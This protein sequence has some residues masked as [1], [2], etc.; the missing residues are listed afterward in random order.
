MPTNTLSLFYYNTT[1]NKWYEART[2]AGHSALRECTITKII[3]NPS[4]AKIILSNPSKNSQTTDTTKSKG[5]LSDVFPDYTHLIIRDNATG[6]ILFRGRSYE[7]Q[8]RYDLSKGALIEIDAYD[9]LR[10]LQETI[11]LDTKNIIQN[12]DITT[13]DGI[14]T[15]EYS[16]Q[17][18]LDGAM[19]DVT[20]STNGFGYRIQFAV[21]AQS[22]TVE[23]VIKPGEVFKIDNEYFR[24]EYVAEN[25]ILGVRGIVMDGSATVEAHADG[26]SLLKVSAVR[27]STNR[28]R[29]NLIK[30]LISR[31]N[32]LISTSL[33]ADNPTNIEPSEFQ[34]T[35]EELTNY[36]LAGDGS[37]RL[38]SIA[39][40]RS[41]L[42]QEIHN[43]ALSDP[44]SNT[45]NATHFGYDYYLG[46][47]VISHLS[48]GATTSFNPT[49]KGYAPEFHYF[50]RGSRPGIGADS[51]FP[52][53]A[54]DTLKVWESSKSV[55]VATITAV[56]N[57]SPSRGTSQS[58]TVSNVDILESLASTFKKDNNDY[59]YNVDV[60][61]NYTVTDGLVIAI[62]KEE[63][64]VTNVT[65]GNNTL[66]VLRGVNNS[67]ISTHADDSPIYIN[68]RLNAQ[69]DKFG[70]TFWYP[71]SEGTGHF[72]SLNAKYKNTSDIPLQASSSF[73]FEDSGYY[74]GVSATFV[75]K[76]NPA[77]ADSEDT[78]GAEDET[79]VVTFEKMPC[80]LGVTDNKVHFV[81]DSDS[82]LGNAR[83]TDD[84]PT[85]PYV[86]VIAQSTRKKNVLASNQRTQFLY[87][88]VKDGSSS[89]I[90]TNPCAVLVSATSNTSPSDTDDYNDTIIL[91]HVHDKDNTLITSADAA[92]QTTMRAQ[93]RTYYDTETEQQIIFEPFPTDEDLPTGE[94]ALYLYGDNITGQARPHLR[95]KPSAARARNRLGL[96]KVGVLEVPSTHRNSK[97]ILQSLSRYLDVKTS[98]R[99][100][101]SH[102]NILSHPHLTLYIENDNISR[103]TYVSSSSGTSGN[104]IIFQSDGSGNKAFINGTTSGASNNLLLHGA[105]LGSVIA[106]LN[107]FNQIVR[108]AYI[109]DINYDVTNDK[110]YL[111]Y[112]VGATDTSDGGQFLIS[113][114]LAADSGTGTS[115]T[116]LTNTG[117]YYN[118][119]EIIKIG[120]EYMLI[121]GV[122]ASG[123]TVQRGYSLSTPATVDSGSIAN[124][125]SGANIRSY[126]KVAIFIPTE[127]GHTV[128]VKHNRVGV[129]Y[130]SIVQTIEHVY[131]GGHVT[132]YIDSIGLINSVGMPSQTSTVPSVPTEDMPNLPDMWGSDS[133]DEKIN[134][135][136]KSI[137]TGKLIPHNQSTMA[138]I[139]T[140]KTQLAAA[141]NDSATTIAVD[142]ASVFKAG[143]AVMVDTEEM[144]ITSI[145]GNTLTIYRG[146]SSE[147]GY[148]GTTRASHSDDEYISRSHVFVTSKAGVVKIK[149]SDPDI[150]GG[151]DIAG[152]NSN[153]NY[154]LHEKHMVF[155]RRK[156][157]VTGETKFGGSFQLQAYPLNRNDKT[158][159]EEDRFPL[160]NAGSTAGN[161]G[162][163]RRKGDIE[164]GI[165]QYDADNDICK[166]EESPKLAE[167][168]FD[169][170]QAVNSKLLKNNLSAIKVKQ[171]GQYWSTNLKIEGTAW[172]QIKFGLKGSIGSDATV[173]FGDD[174]TQ[175]I[176]ASDESAKY[177][178]LS[179]PSGM[180][181][182]SPSFTLPADTSVYLYKTVSTAASTTDTGKTLYFT[183]N[184]TDVYQDDRIL[185]AVIT[186]AASSDA[187]GDEATPAIF[188]FGGAD[189]TFTSAV[190]KAGVFTTGITAAMDGVEINA[191]GQ[192]K[193]PTNKSY[194]SAVNGY[195]LEVNKQ[196]DGS[197]K[198]RFEIGKNDGQYLRWTGDN[199][200]IRGSIKTASNGAELTESLGLYFADSSSSVG[201]VQ[202]LNTQNTSGG[203]ASYTS[204]FKNAGDNLAIRND[205]AAVKT[206][207][208]YGLNL[209]LYNNLTVQGNI[210]GNVTFSNDVLFN[211]DVLFKGLMKT[212]SSPSS[213]AGLESIDLGGGNYRYELVRDTSSRKYKTNIE[214][215]TL[216]SA[217]IYNLNPVSFT[218]K[219]SNKPA[220]GLIAEEVY[221][222]LPELVSLLDG[223]PDTVN[224][225]RLPVLLLAEIK[226]LKTRI[227]TLENS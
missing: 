143:N 51:V 177:T 71:S 35:P 32:S 161:V 184:Y 15:S 99:P 26:A 181:Y 80:A 88:G 56:I 117:T 156:K 72:K 116:I 30:Y 196:G 24:A 137:T 130:N 227:E 20:A 50:K 64:L 167:S 139:S 164:F 169:I 108:Y 83:W 74:T 199:L 41:N 121:T 221:E 151:L 136:F 146:E 58:I 214:S 87:A 101:T 118:E 207:D 208:I 122:G 106:E 97:L 134:E 111:L 112:G 149:I 16:P 77:A 180:S 113:S 179:Y 217:K 66:T 209:D 166:W 141:L 172:N 37:K 4:M 25:T 138:L 133:S 54:A 21:T 23:G 5:N 178:G 218:T 86:D 43:L 62:D 102:L 31:S 110:T 34:F 46:N 73:D 59:R 2:H 197:Y 98:E 182:S 202:W 119:G 189:A 192:I 195:I 158:E 18:D 123:L 226:K 225:N 100:V 155:F 205:G 194:N 128:R 36:E 81:D 13:V 70:L 220:F 191:L 216:D 163:Y 49:Q 14:T 39:A 153:D 95:I 63:F 42:L 67:P 211:D 120:N 29:S 82:F 168:V 60:N 79:H 10:E 85:N 68:T 109:S 9:A 190:I 200:E 8:D 124:H 154:S 11:L 132:T 126:R 6:I 28:Q 187:A 75:I 183:T 170:S 160:W 222:V 171:S 125:S 206:F 93:H 96:S 94:T 144:L 186:T 223:E 47:R 22:G 210:T 162:G 135:E 104:Q 198:P 7:V 203:S 159:P 188:P 148:N 107:S 40:N 3:N 127:P 215:L 115:L 89:T 219:S 213:N 45:N 69:P 57:T 44:W 38:Y 27:S 76:P 193:S 1:D 52:V 61:D 174:S 33:I 55:A 204:F 19:A 90:Q 157:T 173:S 105:K 152:T 131:T 84:N 175:S 147:S 150:N 48:H 129:D 145:S 65:T 165:A 78:D 12:I 91:S 140:A 212:D 185:L 17:M 176:Y 201:Q 53:T 103:N 142:D 92:G 224:Y 114:Q